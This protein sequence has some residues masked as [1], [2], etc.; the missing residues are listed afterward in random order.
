MMNSLPGFE[1]WEEATQL[2]D[3]WKKMQGLEW[4]GSGDTTE[5]T[6]DFGIGSLEVR[7]EASNASIY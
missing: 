1:D 7:Y 5:S 2:D 3:E 4:D 6:T